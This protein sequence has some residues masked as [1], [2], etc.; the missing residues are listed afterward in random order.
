MLKTLL[1]LSR[2]VRMA[3]LIVALINICLIS[4]RLAVIYKTGWSFA[5]SMDLFVVVAT[6]I[7][8][9]VIMLRMAA[10]CDDAL[11]AAREHNRIAQE[12]WKSSHDAA[13]RTMDQFR[14]KS[15]PEY[16]AEMAR[17]RDVLNRAI[18]PPAPVD[19]RPDEKLSS[20]TVVSSAGSLQEWRKLHD[21]TYIEGGSIH[22]DATVAM[23]PVVQVPS[24][25]QPR[26]PRNPGEH[27]PE[28]DSGFPPSTP[29]KGDDT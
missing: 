25:H 4:L 26:G 11:D 28:T 24:S 21:S 12:F 16:Q 2:K 8:V 10:M 1:R 14:E 19:G 13:N 7:L 18:V 27:L 9:F 3:W 23:R 5:S 15:S 6:P 22:E 17:V 20:G 29:D